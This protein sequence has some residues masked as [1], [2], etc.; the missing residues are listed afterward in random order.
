MGSKRDEQQIRRVQELAGSALHR[1]ASSVTRFQ[2]GENADQA[3]SSKAR[4]ACCRHAA[5][6]SMHKATPDDM[7]SVPG[8]VDV[9]RLCVLVVYWCEKVGN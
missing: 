1:R 3:R 4:P 5:S 7:E 2:G 8:K 6:L 9:I